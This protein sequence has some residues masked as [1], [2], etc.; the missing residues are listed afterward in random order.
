MKTIEELEAFMLKH[1]E[2]IV[3]LLGAEI[4]R[5]E[6]KLKVPSAH[7]KY[8]HWFFSQIMATDCH[9]SFSPGPVSRATT[10]GPRSTVISW[11]LFGTQSDNISFAKRFKEA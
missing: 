3:D 2:N 7:G 9:V 8:I 1:G 4:D 10:R 6:Q 11:S 5:I